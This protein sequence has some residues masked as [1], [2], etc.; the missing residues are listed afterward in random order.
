MFQELLNKL[1]DLRSRTAQFRRVAVHLHSPDSYDWGEKRCDPTRND[2]ITLLAE[3]G[4]HTY[5]KELSAHFDIA[6]VT[7]HMRCTYATRV[8]KASVAAAKPL[9]LPG[10]ELNYRL[11]PLYGFTRI[12]L[13]ALF[14]VGVTVELFSRLFAACPGIPE[15]ALRTGQEEISGIELTELVRK[16]HNEGGLCIAAHIESTE[17]LRYRLRKTAKDLLELFYADS[18]N[19]IEKEV[20]LPENLKTYIFE[21]GIDAVEITKPEDST[22]FRWTSADGVSRCIP[23]LL[24]T[25]AHC[26]EEFKAN[27]ATHLK[28]TSVGLDGLKQAFAF[29]ATRVRFPTTVVDTPEQR[30]LGIQIAGAT[31]S[32]FQDVTVA[33]AENLTCIIG[34]RGSGKSTLVESLRYVF[35]YNRTLADLGPLEKP[36]R[37]RQ[38]KNL[39]GSLIRIPYRMKNGEVRVLQ[40]TFDAKSDYSTRVYSSSGELLDVVDVEQSGDYPLR[41]FGWSEIETLGQSPAKQRELLDRLMP[42]VFPLLKRREQVRGELSKNTAEIKKLIE[43]LRIAFSASNQVVTR[44]KEYQADL[45]ALNSPVVQ[46][47]FAQLDSVRSRISVVSA[48]AAN[49]IEIRTGVRGLCATQLTSGIDTL[50]AAASPAI[51]DW[52]SNV[53][54]PAI[55]LHAAENSVMNAV[56][57]IIGGLDA[58]DSRLNEYN[59]CL[60]QELK[61]IRD[62]LQKSFA[63]DANMQRIFDLRANAERRLVE[64]STARH[65]YL[66][67]W[68]NLQRTLAVRD[69]LV[70]SLEDVQTHI[71]ATRKKHNAAVES[72]LNS[73]LPTSMKV[74][75]E[76]LPNRDNGN[77]G[78]L[79]QEVFGAKGNQPKRIRAIVQQCTTPL[80]F[81]RM[82]K[83]R[84]MTTLVGTTIDDD[85]VK[86]TFKP[87]DGTHCL[88][89]FRIIEHHEQADVDI[90]ADG[91]GLSFVLELQDLCFDDH[92]AILLNDGPVNKKS[93]G[94]RSSAMLPLIALAEETPLIIDQPEDNLDKRLIGNVLMRVLASLK[95][96]RQ[97]VVCTHDPNILVGGDAEQVVVL[98]AE[99]DRRATVAN[100]GSIDNEDI[101][102][103]VV[104]LLEGGADAFAAR[105]R[106]YGTPAPGLV[107]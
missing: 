36:I 103:T 28:M 44:F 94:Q 82:I 63:G 59:A 70:T 41:L 74:S 47:Y 56:R 10:M 93:P 64:S 48:I 78:K 101:V 57:E 52:Y 35:G 6:A 92:A 42:E 75:I 2:K 43:E 66:I 98:E 60:D 58:F 34:V 27:R 7:D 46:A 4:E 53:L 22:H 8:S 20:G 26:F 76:F 40:A 69:A 84:N 89:R 99:N 33:F 15:D 90:L 80:Q 65:R 85:G 62:N 79:L 1:T 21:A 95:E 106:R 105:H 55:D 83:E 102:A 50:I 71:A 18:S 96:K 81:A 37:E 91:V 25:D 16:I 107:D 67:I 61:Q 88:E 104:D 54:V 5:L 51:P 11:Q 77:F 73:Y 23:C 9:V 87:E 86:H 3:R 17:G 100:H 97:I 49:A 30:V 12:H 38:V 72:T 29:P 39:E 32:F 68:D 31:T 24:T 13:L 14:P 45:A 19:A